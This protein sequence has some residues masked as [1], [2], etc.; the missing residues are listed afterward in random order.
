MPHQAVAPAGR[1]AIGTWRLHPGHAMSLRPRRASVLRVYCGRVWVTLGGP[2][3]VLGRESGD[4]FLSPGDVLKVPAGARLVM[5][6]LAA[7]GDVQPVHFD[8]SAAPEGLADARFEREVRAPARDAVVLL[9][10]AAVALGRVLR[11]LL[12]YSGW[13][14]RGTSSHA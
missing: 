14:A 8:W 7:A 12:G 4:R 13:R 2:H 6:P 10:Q 9:G 11:G 3:P 5:E 1:Q